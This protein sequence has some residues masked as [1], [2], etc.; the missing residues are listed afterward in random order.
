[1]SQFELF[2]LVL[3]LRLDKRFSVEQFEATLSQSTVASPPL[4]PEGPFE[5]LR[6]SLCLTHSGVR[7]V[8]HLPTILYCTMLYCTVPYTLLYYMLCY[9]MLCSQV[10]VASPCRGGLVYKVGSAS[11]LQTVCD[12]SCLSSTSS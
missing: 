9:V 1:M 7:R 2:E 11:G 4:N 5:S 8:A 10:P 6:P 3:L 12:K